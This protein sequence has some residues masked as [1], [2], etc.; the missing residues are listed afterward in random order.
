VG[1]SVWPPKRWSEVSQNRLR[2]KHGH[3]SCGTQYRE[4]LCWLARACNNLLDWYL[5]TVATQRLGKH[6]PSATRNCWRRFLRGPCR[7][8]GKWAISSYQ[9]FLIISYSC[10]GVR[11]SPLVLRPQLSKHRESNSAR[12]QLL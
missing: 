4:S 5:P 3:E 11:L 1:L 8:K 12:S 2:A 7:I 6:V 10:G 9:K